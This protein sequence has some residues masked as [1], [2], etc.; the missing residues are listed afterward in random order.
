M[1]QKLV[2]AFVPVLHAGYLE[3]FRKH[4]GAALQLLDPELYEGKFGHLLREVRALPLSI[5]CRA[6]SSLGYF[7]EVGLINQS[8]LEAL[9]P[10]VEIIMPDEDVS[11]YVAERYLTRHNPVFESIFLRF[12]MPKTLSSAPVL[13]DRQISTLEFDREIMAQAYDAAQHSPDWWR[14]VG[15]ALV[16][17]GRI[18]YLAYNQHMPQQQVLY[19]VGDPRGNFNA[20]E[21]IDL[22]CAQHAEKVIIS[23]AAA[24]GLSTRGASMY[25]TTL[26]CQSCAADVVEAGISRVYFREGYSQLFARETF[27]S[28]GV[29]L[30]YIPN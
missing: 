16:K 23:H 8:R 1:S 12:D 7:T 5:T 2:I 29:E 27:E 18:I 19:A 21:R 6:I 14:Q 9:N 4:A 26:P 30:V 3:L 15:A 28:R 22:S 20:G 25:V 17:E 10:G 11:H 24:D 13:P